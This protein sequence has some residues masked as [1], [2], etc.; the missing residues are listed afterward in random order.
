[1]PQNYDSSTSTWPCIRWGTAEITK[2]LLD[3]DASIA[4]LDQQFLT[5]LVQQVLEYTTSPPQAEL[6]YADR[7]NIDQLWRSI[8]KIIYNRLKDG[9]E[10]HCTNQNCPKPL[11]HRQP[12]QDQQSIKVGEEVLRRLIADL[13]PEDEA[14][15]VIDNNAP[16]KSL[17]SSNKSWHD[18]SSTIVDLK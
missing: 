6:P 12:T 13:R 4:E 3:A 2:F 16:F 14:E 10:K 9:Y 7:I 18:N 17:C 5:Y 15:E 1:M 8:R 11:D